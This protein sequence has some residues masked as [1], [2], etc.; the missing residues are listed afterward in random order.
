MMNEFD[1]S[2]VRDPGGGDETKVVKDEEE[3]PFLYIPS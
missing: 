2:V 3:L 1:P